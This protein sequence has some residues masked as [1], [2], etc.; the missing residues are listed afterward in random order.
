MKIFYKV[1]C[2]NTIDNINVGN[3]LNIS[4]NKA[5][6]NNLPIGDIDISDNISDIKVKLIGKS[7]NINELIVAI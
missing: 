4:N 7:Y 3:T 2:N 6:Y 5:Y 1:K